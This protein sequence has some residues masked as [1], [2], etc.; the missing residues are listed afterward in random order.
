MILDLLH[1]RQQS[2]YVFMDDLDDVDSIQAQASSGK[3]FKNEVSMHAQTS[4]T[5]PFKN[6]VSMMKIERKCYQAFIMVLFCCL[7]YFMMKCKVLENEK[8]FLR[9]S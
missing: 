3:I 2:P 9:L 5:K 1:K 6:E 7:L 8:K 4:S